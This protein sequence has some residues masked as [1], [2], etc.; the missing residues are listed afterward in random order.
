MP[1]ARTVCPLGV[2]VGWMGAEFRAV[3][4]ER[5]HRGRIT[6]ETLAFLRNAFDAE[7]DVTT[8]NGQPFVFRP[9]PKRIAHVRQAR[10]VVCPDI[11]TM[12][13]A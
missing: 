1:E 13:R 10:L 3:G 11:Q 7:D 4:I 9:R 12:R 2:G 6:D 5:R 8:S